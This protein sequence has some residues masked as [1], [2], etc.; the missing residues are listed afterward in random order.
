M[1]SWSNHR[2]MTSRQRERMPMGIL[3]RRMPAVGG[4]GR[5]RVQ[6]PTE[7]SVVGEEDGDE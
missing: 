4:S 2:T 3:S 7:A 1:A 5:C 6:G